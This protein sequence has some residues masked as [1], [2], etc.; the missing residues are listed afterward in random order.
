MRK[1]IQIKKII[2]QYYNAD[3]RN[4]MLLCYVNE[5]KQIINSK[6]DMEKKFPTFYAGS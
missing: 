1:D 4:S 2:K 6:V 3:I 5:N